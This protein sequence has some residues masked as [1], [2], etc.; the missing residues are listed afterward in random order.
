[1]VLILLGQAFFATGKIE[2]EAGATQSAMQLQKAAPS[3]ERVDLNRETRT[4]S[5]LQF[6]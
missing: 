4:N 6:E 3:D 5:A 1:M 2:E